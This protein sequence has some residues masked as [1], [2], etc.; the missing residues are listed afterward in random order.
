[1]K[2]Q[3]FLNKPNKNKTSPMQVLHSTLGKTLGFSS[4]F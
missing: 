2:I 3:Q 1:M 4:H